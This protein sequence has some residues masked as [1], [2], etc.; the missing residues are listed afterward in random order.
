MSYSF[1]LIPDW[2]NPQVVGINKLPAHTTLIPYP[3]EISALTGRREQSPFFQPLNGPWQFRLV[4][5]PHAAPADFS[6]PNFDAA[7]WDALPVPSNWMM[8]GY[9]NPIYTNVKMPIPPNPPYVP[10]DDNPTGLYRRTFTIPDEWRDRQ[11]FICFDGVE[12]AFYLWVNGRPVGYSQDSRLPAEFDLTA[13][14]RPG[15]NR[16][17]AMVIRWSDGSYLEDQDH[18]WMA[19]IYRDVYLYAAPKVH[20]FDFFVR[21]EFEA[22]YRDATLRVQARV[23]FYERPAPATA[24]PESRYFDP[25]STEYSIAMQLYDAE[26]APVLPEPVSRPVQLSDWADNVV[27]LLQPVANPR[28]WSAEDPYLYTLVLLLKNAQGETIEA[29]SCQIGFRQVEIKGR[30]LLINGR[31]VLL[32]GVNRHDFDERRGKTVT[33]ESML[34]DVRLL[35]QF[36][37]NAVR[38][39]HY[40]NDPRWYDLCD[41]YGL[42]LIDEA[43]IECHALYNKLPNNPQWATAF[44]E[45]GMRLV[46]RDKNHPSVI[47]WSLG[48][49]SGYGPNHDAIAGWIRGYDPTRPLHYEGA[50]SPYTM[51][52]NGEQVDFSRK[53]DEAE[54]EAARRRGWQAGQLVSDVFSTM[55]PT[56]NHIIA[57]AQDP[58]NTRPLIMCEYAH[59]MGNSTGNLK[60]YWQAVE[61]YHGLQGGFIWDWVDQGLLKVDEEGREYWAYGGDF[62]DDINDLNF[63]INGLIWPDRTPHPAMF[64]CKKLFQPLAVEAVDLAQGRLKIFNKQYFAT[65]GNLA[66]SWEVQVDGRPVQQGDLPRLDL[67]PQQDQEIMIPIQKP[68]LPP[69]AETFLTVCFRLAAATPWA[70]AGHKVAWEQFKLPF[71]SPTTV[72]PVEAMSRLALTDRAGQLIVTG[73]D[74]RLAFDQ[75]S[76]TLASFVFR[77]TEML[78]AGPVLNAW[79]APTDNDGFKAQPHRPD[80]LLGQWLATGLNRLEQQV[81]SLVV[82][83]TKPQTVRISARFVIRGSAAQPGFIHRQTCTIYGCGDVVFANAIE[84][85]PALPPLPR[86]GLTLELP[87]GFE[88]FSW[89]GRGPHENYIDRNAGAAVGLYHSTVDEQYV[90]YIMPQENGNKTDVRWLTLT[91]A[92][93]LGLL[94]VGAPPLEVSVSHFTADDLYRAYHTNE[95]VRRPGVSLNLDVRQCGLGGAS[96]GP[97]TLPQYLVLPGAVTF[98]VRLRPFVAGQ[99]Q[100]AE[101]A[102]QL[103][104]G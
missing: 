48:N 55:Y 67:P 59:S 8:H 94:A 104:A 24:R 87:A 70:E 62:G 66:G 35:K 43:N 84:A 50:T 63:C 60:E 1:H 17:A 21:T 13:Y 42:Y 9:D 77:D 31:P 5:N 2:E 89:Y 41:Q 93:G 14:V 45:R 71:D 74:F 12:S 64:E 92:A 95:L 32:K 38:T 103:L 98:T 81:E 96:C 78:V 47:M 80:K 58:A 22:D 99:D 75:G 49:E 19:G 53:P 7:D 3:D 33:L 100:P 18:W 20:I 76:G 39:A 46:Q 23:N 40:P 82:E 68:A 25:G 54:Q 29:E 85:D 37:F 65:L 86:I 88:Q 26:G 10:H 51:L 30:E 83:Q 11:I 72:A 102:R 36:N 69:G 91:N 90:P 57:Y 73:P 34:A 52:L 6:D 97:G 44:L 79:R 56:V 101:L 28:Q 4:A 15:L 16:L 61:Q 27:R